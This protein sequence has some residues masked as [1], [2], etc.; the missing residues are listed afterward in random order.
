MATRIQ[1]G[2]SRRTSGKWIWI[3][4]IVIIVIAIG[5]IF[6]FYNNLKNTTEMK[7]DAVSYLI[8]YEMPQKTELYF[9]RIKNQS[10]KIF[11]VKSPDNIFYSEKGLYIDSLK[12]EEALT[13]FEQ[14]FDINPSTVKY[15]FILKNDN[16]PAFLSIIKGQGNTIDDVFEYLKTRKSGIMDMLVANNLINEVRKYGNTNLSYNGA[17][18]FLQ[19]FSKYSITSYDKLEIKTLL[20]KPVVINLPDLKKKMERNYVDKTTLESLKTILE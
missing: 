3:L 7:A 13:N 5:G 16:I 11:I 2:N 19:A 20:S 18:A 17:F 9:V 1:V 12:P 4:L 6:Y 10:R 15:H 8:T 14:M